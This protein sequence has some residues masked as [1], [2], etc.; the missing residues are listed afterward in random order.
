MI[1]PNKQIADFLNTKI[2]DSNLIFINLWS[3][4]HLFSGFFLMKYFIY[5]KTNPLLF[6]F[7]LLVLYELFELI[8]IK[9]G[10][11]LF[12]PESIADIAWDLIVGIIGGYIY[13]KW[14]I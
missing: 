6:L 14:F 4:I 2:I 1:L 11:N 9:S 3:I 5:G 8:V 12:R 13:L 10:S 7:I